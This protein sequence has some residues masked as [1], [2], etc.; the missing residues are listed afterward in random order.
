MLQVA[1]T[2]SSPAES[3]LGKNLVRLAGQ[4]PALPY[5]VRAGTESNSRS[6]AG[7]RDDGDLRPTARSL[8]RSPWEYQPHEWCTPRHGGRDGDDL[9]DRS[10]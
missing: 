7:G 2:H 8:A 5:A 9:I 10:K 4:S 3:N 1:T 6:L